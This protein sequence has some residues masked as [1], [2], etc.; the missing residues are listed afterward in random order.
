MLFRPPRPSPDPRFER[1]QQPQV[2]IDFQEERLAQ[3]PVRPGLARVERG[4][5]QFAELEDQVELEIEERLG[6]GGFG[7]LRVGHLDPSPERSENP[8]D[9][10]QLVL[11]PSQRDVAAEPLRVEQPG[12][13]EPGPG[14]V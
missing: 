13:L 5:G 6:D 9:V 14:L 1:L 3:E 2:L 7:V 11:Q 10:A 8:W 12:Q 4:I